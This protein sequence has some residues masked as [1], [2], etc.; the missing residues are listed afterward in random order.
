MPLHSPATILSGSIAGDL[1]QER[2]DATALAREGG[3]DYRAVPG[4]GHLLQ[5]E[6]SQ[7]CAD[8]VREFLARLGIT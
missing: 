7:A 4:T 3:Y 5:L 2:S 6:K 8:A 1:Q